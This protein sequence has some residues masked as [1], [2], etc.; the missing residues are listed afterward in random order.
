[1]PGTLLLKRIFEELAIHAHEPTKNKFSSEICFSAV[2]A[3]AAEKWPKNQGWVN[4]STIREISGR[5]PKN[6][7]N[8]WKLEYQ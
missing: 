6:L 1:M 5:I 2:S 8:F 3:S 4:N 7:T